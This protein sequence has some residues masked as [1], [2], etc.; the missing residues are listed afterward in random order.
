MTTNHVSKYCQ[1]SR[2]V[3]WGC[4]LTSS[5]GSIENKL[6]ILMCVIPKA[7]VL[8]PTAFPESLFPES[9]SKSALGFGWYQNQFVTEALN[10]F[11]M[12]LKFYSPSQMIEKI[13]VIQYL[14]IF[15][16]CSPLSPHITPNKLEIFL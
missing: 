10:G 7:H 2:E 15:P 4:A 14:L 3:Q 16:F 8:F 13:E 1:M 11:S 6:Q 12:L 5:V 9:K